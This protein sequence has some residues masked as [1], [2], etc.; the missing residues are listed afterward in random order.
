MDLLEESE[1]ITDEQPLFSS[2]SSVSSVNDI[3]Q[4]QLEEEEEEVEEMDICKQEKELNESCIEEELF[5]E[6]T[7]VL[8][9][10]ST[11]IQH[12]EQEKESFLLK[13]ESLETLHDD[14]STLGINHGSTHGISGTNETKTPSKVI[15]EFDPLHQDWMLR[16]DTP[17][18]SMKSSRSIQ[19]QNHETPKVQES[20]IDSI[21]PLATPN[22]ICQFTQR[23]MDELKKRLTLQFEKEFEVA[24]L[25]IQEMEQSIKDLNDLTKRTKNE[26]AET[27]IKLS[28]AQTDREKLVAHLEKLQSVLDSLKNEKNEAFQERDLIMIKYKQ[29][30]MDYDDMREVRF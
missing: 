4:H 9:I 20:L 27:Q 14:S 6:A 19:N 22:S 21:G 23:D 18:V 13:Q 2:S 10:E 12:L 28:S 11:D 1:F 7:D 5:H 25:E 16:F 3:E 30:K 8:S 29:L 24:Q 15:S 26:L 17:T